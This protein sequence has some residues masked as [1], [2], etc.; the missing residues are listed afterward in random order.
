MRSK[1]ASTNVRLVRAG[2]KGVCIRDADSPANSLSVTEKSLG[3]VT[4]WLHNP[5]INS[6]NY[7][8]TQFGDVDN[9]QND[10]DTCGCEFDC[11][12]SK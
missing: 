4:T 10:F 3:H 7:S 9:R 8:Y 6:N 5:S 1:S 2:I 12:S 11:V